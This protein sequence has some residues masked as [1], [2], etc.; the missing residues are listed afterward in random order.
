MSKI[1]FRQGLSFDALPPSQVIPMVRCDDLVIGLQN[2][3]RE[4]S[5]AAK[6]KDLHSV[7]V[8]LGDI[9]D[10]VFALLGV[11]HHDPHI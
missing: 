6:T 3:E 9:L 7:K 5:E 8:P 2:L 10:D 11:D 1:V 4:W